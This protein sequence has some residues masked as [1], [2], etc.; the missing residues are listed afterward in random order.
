MRQAYQRVAAMRDTDAHYANLNFR[1]ALN[2]YFRGIREFCELIED[3]I[4]DLAPRTAEAAEETTDS[5]ETLSDDEKQRVANYKPP[6]RAPLPTQQDYEMM[7]RDELEREL[8]DRREFHNFPKQY[9]KAWLVAKLM[10]LDQQG[11][12]G[13]GARRGYRSLANDPTAR[14]RPKGFNLDAAIRDA[15]AAKKAEKEAAQ[16][17]MAAERTQKRRN[18]G[19]PSSIDRGQTPGIFTHSPDTSSDEARDDSEASST[20][21]ESV[22]I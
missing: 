19:L 14:S 2:R 15:K 8:I 5:E 3:Y 1:H 18:Q 21:S 16:K 9:T 17:Q 12:L 7:F 6:S 22:P 10:E 20:T 11:N 4:R 13:C